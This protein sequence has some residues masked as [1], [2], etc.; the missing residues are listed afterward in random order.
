MATK[1]G[2]G[3]HWQCTIKRAGLLPQPFC[4]GFVSEAEG[5]EYVRRLEALLD[6]GVVPEELASTT[7]PAKDLRRQTPE[8]CPRLGD[9]LDSGERSCPQGA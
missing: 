7:A 9:R 5:D 1:R 2:R 3:D 4:L 6:R 8:L